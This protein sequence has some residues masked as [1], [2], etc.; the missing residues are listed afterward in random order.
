MTTRRDVLGAYNATRGPG[1]STRVPCHAPFLS[2]NFEQSGRVTACCYNR[3]YVLGT[4]PRHSLRAIWTGARARSMR[5]AFLNDLEAP[6]CNLCFHQLDSGN[7]G[8]VLMR[9]FDAYSRDPDYRPEVDPSTP[10]VLEFEIA[11]T[12]NLECVMCEG[13]WSSAIRAHRERLPPLP[14]PYDEAF[15]A[16]LEPFLPALQ[17]AKFLGGEPFLIGRYYEIW[18]RIRLANPGADLMVTTNATLL[19][20]RAR[21][22]FEALR[23]HVVVSLD[24]LDPATFETI[25]KNARFEE[26]MANVEYF[27]DYARR[28]QTSLSLAV[29][30]MTHNWKELP[31]LLEFCEKRELTVRFNTV[32]R[33]AEATLA[34]LSADELAHVIGHLEGF[35]PE[36]E[37]AWTVENRQTW[38][39]LLSQ[40]S[41]WLEEKREF[42][43]RSSDF[44]RRLRSFAARP[45]GWTVPEAFDR[46]APS[47]ALSLQVARERSRKGGE[48]WG[49]R[50]LVPRAPIAFPGGGEPLA[51]GDVLLATHILCRFVGEM[52]SADTAVRGGIAEE[53][54]LLRQYVSA[55]PDGPESRRVDDLGSWMRERI[56]NGEGEELVHWM[57]TLLD[58]LERPAAWRRGIEE[59]QRLLRARG[60]DAPGFRKV[61]SYLEVAI[62]PFIPMPGVSSWGA[63]A[64][65]TPDRVE[66]A[67][68]FDAMFVF[69]VCR[70]PS[71]DHEAFRRRLD[72]SLS[73]LEAAGKEEAARQ[74]MDNMGFFFVYRLLA[75]SSDEELAGLLSAFR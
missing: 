49:L 18:E 14:S 68:V 28:K 30:P 39:G 5:E 26:V 64:A 57:R 37:D 36:G 33:P 41:A 59:S 29:C 66:L 31:G 58:A 44:E 12:C 48:Q 63:G 2:L 72:S 65:A 55:T 32:I 15:V 71:G 40:L 69:H 11:N 61:A 8:G 27:L 23:F 73:S 6:G 20:P 47:L 24:A 10:R 38:N 53:Q 74:A 56:R 51:T 54:R 35:G 19:P 13:H 75:G 67:R 52:E 1:V 25:R 46:M 21:E 70:E 43:R 42:A 16:E 60:L 3:R 34:S 4:Y 7:F 22:L 50:N 45:V 9:N 62:A 17:A